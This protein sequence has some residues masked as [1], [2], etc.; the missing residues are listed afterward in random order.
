[1]L[2]RP[3]RKMS[4]AERVDQMIRE[5]F[6]A[7]VADEVLSKI[8]VVVGDLNKPRLGLTDD[9]YRQLTE[10][11][12]HIMHVG[13]S[14][15][16]GLN[17]SESRRLN[18]GSTQEMLNLAEQCSRQSDFYRLEYVSTA[19]VAGTMRGDVTEDQLERGQDFANSY[20]Q[21]KFEAEQLVRKYM[22]DIPTAIYRPSII[23]GDSRTGF[24]PHFKILYFPLKIAA[25]K[26]M[27]FFPCN[28][29]AVLDSVPVDYVADGMAAL[30]VRPENTGRTFHLTAGRGHELNIG[31][32]IRDAAAYADIPFPPRIPLW[33][34]DI[35]KHRPLRWF[36][37]SKFWE[38]VDL[39]APYRAYFL[40]HSA[41]FNS[42]QTEA[43]LRPLGV[44]APRWDDYS[45]AVLSYIAESNWG[46]K[47]TEHLL[48]RTRWVPPAAALQHAI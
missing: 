47:A 36:V 12:H 16:F 31:R 10:Q 34:F 13:A 15:N 27:P 26:I 2:V 46:K 43:A 45:Q 28:M 29:A 41:T 5:H 40:G 44:T 17:L 30:A 42:A 39:V 11:A 6:P 4:A 37:T 1:L 8:T 25:K 20:E 18:V 22:G 7:D 32:L 38:T 19:F 24:T 3:S 21:S 48:P 23:V 33:L 9:T 35:L 14:T